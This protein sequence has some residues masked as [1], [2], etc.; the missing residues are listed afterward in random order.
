MNNQQ[1]RTQQPMSQ[2][3]SQPNKQSYLDNVLGDKKE[4]FV[5]NLASLTS[6]NKSLSECTNIS[7]MSGAIVATSLNLSL[8]KSFGYAY[9]VPFNN[10]STKEKEAQ[11]QIG[12]KGYIQLAMRS[13]AYLRLNAIP[14]HKNKFVSWD[15]M[16][17]KLILNDE[18]GEGEI[19]GYVAFFELLNGFKKTMFWSYEKMLN[20]ADTYSMAFNRFSYKEL[21]EGKIPSKDMWKYSS[22]W[23]K[24]FDDMGL[25]T[26]LRQL[27]SKYGILS[28]EMEQAY[29]F[30]HAVI[31]ENNEPVYVDN[32]SD[33]TTAGETIQ[34]EIIDQSD[35]IIPDDKESTGTVNIKDI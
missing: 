7:V 11:F 14:V 9:L 28:E 3:L 15:D 35:E 20:H 29:R 23:Y 5:T 2:F 19:A 21:K 24:S 4:R 31:S 17:E 8:N 12:Y 10:K 32:D 33:I 25:K 30:D 18:D 26:M 13:G 27:L 1:L 22:F 6:Q 34:E 16:E